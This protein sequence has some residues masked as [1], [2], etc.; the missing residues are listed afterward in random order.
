MMIAPMPSPI[1]HAL[2]G[3]AIAWTPLKRD[4]GAVPS[5]LICALLAALPD[6]DLLYM[7]VHRTA[8]HSLFTALAVFIVAAAVTG[9]VKGRVSWSFAAICAAAYASHA[10]CDWMGKDASSPYG[11]Q[12]LWPLSDRWFISPWRIF[13]GTERRSILSERSILINL[14]AAVTEILIFG[15]VVAL[16]WIRRTRRSRVPTSVQDSRPQP[17]A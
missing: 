9:Q 5:A 4:T 3:V 1:G 2:A 7:P 10:V 8:T 14:R 13:P 11:V 15:P 6:I 16:L 17:S 12:I